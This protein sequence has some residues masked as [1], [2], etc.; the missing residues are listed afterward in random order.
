MNGGRD[1]FHELDPWNPAARARLLAQAKQQRAEAIADGI[2]AV[3]R[4]LAAVMRA[5]T[6]ALSRRR[7]PWD[8]AAG[9]RRALEGD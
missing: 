3:W 4:G 8:L 9:R 7:Q 6:A 5:C 1:D 2:V